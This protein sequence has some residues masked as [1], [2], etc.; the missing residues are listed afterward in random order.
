MAF[1]GYGGFFLTKNVL[2][3]FPCKKWNEY[4]QKY[5]NKTIIKYRAE[6]EI[7]QINKSKKLKKLNKCHLRATK[8]KLKFSQTI[9]SSD[10]IFKCGKMFLR[11][12]C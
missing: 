1:V 10:L 6:H 8:E 4:I 7:K 9:N 5:R 3:R 2:I 11:K 12:F